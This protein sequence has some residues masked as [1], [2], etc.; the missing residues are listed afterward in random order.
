MVDACH[1]AA[2]A[3][4]AQHW[5]LAPA[6]VA[7]IEG[8]RAWNPQ[9][10]YGISN[11]VRLADVMMNRI[12]LAFGAGTNGTELERT[13]GEG[14]ALMRVDDVTIRRLTHGFK[15]RIAVLSTIRG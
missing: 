13:F 7:G 15:E 1:P 6:V 14:R 9:D 12:G 5:D 4:V 8:T 11:M 3:A 10:V 2:G